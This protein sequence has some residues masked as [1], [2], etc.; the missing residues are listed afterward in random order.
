M[1]LKEIEEKLEKDLEKLN[2]HLYS[3]KYKK[4]DKILEVLIDETLDLDHISKLS[5]KISKLMDKYDDEFD[6]YVLDVASAGC[7]REIEGE[8]QILKAINKYVHIKTKDK[9]LN[10]TL[11]EYKNDKLRIE[12]FDKTRKKIL[13]TNVKDVKKLRYAVNFKGEN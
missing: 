11:I 3:L 13:E 7:E 2:Y 9:E 4:K 5:E 6:D 1:N 8:S 10:G 12:Y